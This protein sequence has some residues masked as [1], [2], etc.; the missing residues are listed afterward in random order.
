MPTVDRNKPQIPTYVIDEVAS[1]AGKG[2]SV[3][4]KFD[5]HKHWNL[6]IGHEVVGLSVA[7][8]ELIP[9]EMAWAQFNSYVMDHNH[10]LI[11]TK[12]ERLVNESL[13]V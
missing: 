7:H 9:I 13:V 8:S 3:S 1:Q 10:K 12:V 6:Y 11:L 2:G 4:G 5:V